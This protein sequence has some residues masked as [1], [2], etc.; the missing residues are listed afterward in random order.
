MENTMITKIRAVPEPVAPV[1]ELSPLVAARAD[2]AEIMGEFNRIAEAQR[3]VES[4]PHDPRAGQ[5]QSLRQR[6][7]RLL[8]LGR[9]APSPEVDMLSD[10]LVEAERAERRDALIAEA[11]QALLA[12]LT[13]Q[14]DALIPKLNAARQRLAAAQFDAATA[15]INAQLIPGLITAANQLSA[16]YGKL[17]GAGRAHNALAHALRNF[18]ITRQPLGVE[19]PVTTISVNVVGFGFDNHGYNRMVLNAA[20]ASEAA[21]VEML[22]RWSGTD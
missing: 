18:G 5:A 19:R 9:G 15:E 14:R 4:A 7:G 20:E 11:K 13:A 6:I 17:V 2:I 3:E 22:A 21:Y 8:M 16:A 10:E 12:D 1:V